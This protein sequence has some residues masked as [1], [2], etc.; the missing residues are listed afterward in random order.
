MVR[1]AIYGCSPV[2]KDAKPEKP[3]PES[4]APEDGAEGEETAKKKGLG[5]IPMVAAAVVAAGV[6]GGAAFVLAPGGAGD[7]PGC[8]VAEVDEHGESK[9]HDEDA[10]HDEAAAGCAEATADDHG[11]DKGNKDSDHGK[12]GKKKKSSGGHGGDS[13]ESTVKPLG[14]IQ[15]SAHATFLVLEPMIV[16]IQPIGR[17]KHLKVSLVLETDDEGAEALQDSGFYVQDV[18]NTFL[19]SVDVAVLEDPAS[20]SRLR[21]QILRRIRAI[22]PDAEVTNVLITEFVLT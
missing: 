7:A 11:G 3:D 9:S 18:L 10:T 8:V 1:S 19:R 22:V 4:G 14:E 17:S 12:K 16:S 2:S 15:H 13:A 20:M 5:L 6:A 21:A